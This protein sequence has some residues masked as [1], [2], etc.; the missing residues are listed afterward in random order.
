MRLSAPGGAVERVLIELRQDSMARRRLNL[1]ALVVA[2]T[3]GGAWVL[4]GFLNEWRGRAL[5]H[6]AAALARHPDTPENA[7]RIAN[8]GRTLGNEQPGFGGSVG[9]WEARARI[10]ALAAARAGNPKAAE[11]LYDQAETAARRGL[12]ISPVAAPIWKRLAEIEAARAGWANEPAQALAKTVREVAPA[13]PE[14]AIW[15]VEFVMAHWADLGNDMRQPAMSDL[16]GLDRL[17]GYWRKR[18]Q[19]IA[20]AAPADAL[21]GLAAVAPSLAA[22]VRQAPAPAPTAAETLDTP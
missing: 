8:L 9:Y 21:D 6:E 13:D 16:A 12:T 10:L 1:Y 2:L 17:G 3:L 22:L 18:A 19:E 7:A 5:V 4:I 15:R 20:A 14:A 11:T